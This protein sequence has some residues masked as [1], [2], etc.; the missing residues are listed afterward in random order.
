MLRPDAGLVHLLAALEEYAAS[1][2]LESAPV[3]HS[4]FNGQKYQPLLQ[5]V[6]QLQQGLESQ[7]IKFTAAMD[8][9]IQLVRAIFI[10][11][12]F[13]VVMGAAVGIYFIYKSIVFPWCICKMLCSALTR[14]I[15][16][17]A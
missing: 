9:Q 5:Q 11:L 1:F 6:A 3:Q 2:T 12:I 13:V 14:V 16:R 7:L 8:E 17:R 10:A 4:E 15:L